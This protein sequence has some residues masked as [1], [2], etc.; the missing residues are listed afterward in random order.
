[1]EHL[2]PAGSPD[3]DNLFTDFQQ[4]LIQASVGKRLANYLIDVVGFWI[5]I[6]ILSN[7][8]GYIIRE[9]YVAFLLSLNEFEVFCYLLAF[10]CI[11]YIVFEG[12]TRGRT[13]GKLIT[14]SRAVREDGSGISFG[15]A[16]GRT[17]SR[18]VPFEFISILFSPR[19]WHDEWTNSYVIDIKKSKNPVDY[20][21]Y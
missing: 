19:P 20:P 15:Q 14:G 16:V 21:N 11:Y 10:N 6:I 17:F 13:L 5:F 7:I 18:F 2:N 8:L 9:P 1:M 4:T 3:N 12:S